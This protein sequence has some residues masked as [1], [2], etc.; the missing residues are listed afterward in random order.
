MTLVDKLLAHITNVCYRCKTA[1]KI[2]R[3]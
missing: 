2:Y 3:T 1:I